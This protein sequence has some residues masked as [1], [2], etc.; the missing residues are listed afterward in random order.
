MYSNWASWMILRQ[1]DLSAQ[2]PK[3]TENSA[4]PQWLR[5]A[6]P[7]RAGAG[8]CWYITR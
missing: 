6:K 4:G 3:Y 7:G 8:N 1:S 5:R 2:A